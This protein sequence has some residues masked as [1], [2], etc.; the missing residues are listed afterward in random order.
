MCRVRGL[1]CRFADSNSA[2]QSELSNPHSSMIY[3]RGTG[4]RRVLCMFVD[5][6]SSTA[7]LVDLSLSHVMAVYK[8]KERGMGRATMCM[9]NK[10]TK[11]RLSD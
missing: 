1:L 8:V 10:C 5:S 7:N 6:N 3:K 11:T 2:N 4:S 9:L